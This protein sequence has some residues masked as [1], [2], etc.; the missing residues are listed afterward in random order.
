M[1]KV[2]LGKVATMGFLLTLINEAQATAHL[3]SGPYA[4]VSVGLSNLSGSQNFNLSNP[5]VGASRPEFRLDLSAK[6][7]NA[8]IFGGYGYKWNA[9]WT[10]IELSYLFDRVNSEQKIKVDSYV[11]DK[12]LKIR[13]AGAGQASI[14]LG[15]SPHQNWAIYAIAGI[16]VRR[17]QVSFRDQANDI[18]AQIDKKYTSIAFVPGLGILA[19][20]TQNLA[21]RGE[22]KCSLHRSKAVS[23]SAPHTGGAAGN[24]TITLKSLP[25]VHTFKVGV[26]YCF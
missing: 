17:F 4:G 25:Q 18:G 5:T 24:D 14:H 16:E 26:V 21:F 15:Y 10:S 11:Y 7:V 3:R 20:I 2:I 19:K 9:Y 6:S 13:S 23:V 12:I 22:Y 1:K 8:G